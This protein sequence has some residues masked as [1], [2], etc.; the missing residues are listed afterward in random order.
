MPEDRTKV[1]WYH[2]L[3]DSVLILL[4]FSLMLLSVTQIV[5]RNLFEITL[6]W[7]DPLIRHLVL[8][9]GLLGAGVATRQQR[10]LRIDA[11]LRIL[12][13][14]LRPWAEG[15]GSSFAC[16]LC[17]VLCW[18]SIHF[19]HDERKF[20]GESDI[21]LPVWILQIIFPITFS[22]ISFRFGALALKTFKGQ[23][24]GSK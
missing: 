22:L 9:S 11:G 4:T 10:H 20:S 6:L 19:I 24:T 18:I 16:V 15:F 12:P 5:L 13:L 8:W 3:E 14:S 1:V 17:A 2:Q 23:L 7:A 21:G